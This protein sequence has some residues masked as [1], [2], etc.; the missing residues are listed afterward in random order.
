MAWIIAGI[1]EI[2]RQIGAGGGGI[3][4]L[5][6]HLRLNKQIVLKADKRTLKTD[7]GTLRR[8]VDMLKGLRHTFIPQVYDFVQEDGVVY[9]VM[10]YIEGESLDR[11]LKR[12][13]LPGQPQVIAWACELLEALCYLHSRPPHGIL[14]GDIKPA[15]IMLRPDG[16][17]CL[18]DY[19][20]ALVLGEDGAVRVGFSRGYASPEHYGIEYARK[21]AGTGMSAW[22]EGMEGNPH[23]KTTEI[24]DKD[25]YEGPTVTMALPGTSGFG[26]SGEISRSGGSS[27]SRAEIRLDVR[28][29]IYSLGA[30]LYHLLS[31]QRPAQ[32]AREV[33]PLGE[34]ICSPAVSAIIKKAMEPDPAMRFQSADEMLAAFRQLHKRD[35]RVLRRKKRAALS[36]VCCT[37]LFLAGGSCAFVGMKRMEKLQEALV[38][39]E[40]SSNLLREGDIAGAVRLAL[41]ALPAGSHFFDL[42]ETAQAQKAL[43]DAL[44]VYDLSDGFKTHGLLELP[45][46]PFMVAASPDGT[47]LAAVCEN[48]LLIIELET[49]GQIAA[50]PVQTSALSE[51]VFVD[52]SRI[53]Y[54]GAEGVTAYDVKEQEVLWIGE[55]ATTIAVSGDKTMVAAVHRDDTHAA[56]YRMEDGKKMAECDF[57]GQHMEVASNDIFANPGNRVFS[58]NEDGRFL[59]VSFSGGDLWIFDLQ[60]HEGDMVVY[61]ETAY[62]DFSGGFCG[63]YFAFAAN[64]S[65]EAMFGLIDTQEGV[66]IAALESRDHFYLEASERGIFL[67]NQNILVELDTETFEETELAY[68]EEGY[69]SG[70][71]VGTGYVLAL[72]EGNSYSFFDSGANQISAASSETDID[73][74]QMAG[75]YAVLAGRSGP[76]VQ[77]LKNESHKD[78]TILT[79]DARYAHE[80]ARI[81]PEDQTAMLFSYTGFRIYDTEGAVLA[82]E[83]LPDA[84]LVYDQQF[85]RGQGS[86]WL[87]AIWYDGTVRCYSAADGELLSETKEEPP[88]AAL[89]EEFYTSQY[90]I[91]S[92]LHSAPVAYDL[93]TGKRVASLETDGYLT[94]VTQAGEYIVT[95]YVRASGERYGLLLNSRLETLAYLPGLCDIVDDMLVFDYGSGD[96]RQCRFYSLQELEALG[97]SY[98]EMERKG[99]TI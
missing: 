83:K 71:S 20:I 76:M 18:I 4:Y 78:S 62:E 73:F 70:Y 34:D 65:D 3:V 87:K 72:A 23:E 53:I 79:Y 22:N 40:Y 35:P 13:K 38:T 43:T 50:L 66:Y 21:S 49:G 67:A 5:G 8:E 91:E 90:R 74:A 64:K 26:K 69:I 99:E 41:E 30:T 68:I 97:E 52:E 2:E 45:S 39:A 96:L 11:L 75:D 12:G 6:R 9:T 61:E 14:H 81:S 7:T 19:N 59:A 16:H 88:D 60:D 51:V 89:Y 44:G 37:A 77:I 33:A 57:E 15:N 95:E 82:E 58:L 94:Y 48:E 10:D 46:A 84:E 56:L 98:I 17:I 63:R 47:L 86:A 25:H 55:R 85:E 24:M 54:A 92:A 32:N 80:E 28:S 93:E 42:P 36:A 27:R 29:D 1:Y 31:G